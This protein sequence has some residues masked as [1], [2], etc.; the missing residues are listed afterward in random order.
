[1]GYQQL[2]LIQSRMSTKNGEIFSPA[3][4]R[5]ARAILD[6]TQTRLAE[7]AS[8]GLSTVVDFEKSRRAVSSEAIDALR[9]ALEKAGIQFIARN[10]GGPGI[11]LKK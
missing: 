6:M 5:A 3:Q 9:K 8:L 7:L 11:R 4:C 10:G 1:M 2:L